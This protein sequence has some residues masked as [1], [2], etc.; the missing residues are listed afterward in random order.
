MS[1]VSK[2]SLRVLS[3]ISLT[4]LLAACGGLSAESAKERLLTADDFDF[5]VQ[6]DSSPSD[7]SI[8]N[9]FQGECSEIDTAER[10][11]L[12]STVV[13]KSE[14]EE[15]S[16]S[17]NGFSL[18]QYVIQFPTK[19]DASTFVAN[20]EKVARNSDCEWYYSTTSRGAY[21]SSYGIGSED[22]GNVRDLQTAFKVD[23][24]ESVVL[25][26]DSSMV[27]SGTFLSS[28]SSD[29][30]GAAF[31]TSGDLVVIVTYEVE[32]DDIRSSSQPVTRLNLE[33]VVGLA[34]KKLLG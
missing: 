1:F 21:G 27:I 11:Y 30:G 20:V 24:D 16:D 10:D 33:N 34:F 4:F 19:E 8:T 9:I 31:A 28:N 5:E 29:E 23:A 7:P 2:S 3:L 13:A 15:R 12:K 26:I 6:V 17:Q 25:D 18:E 22:F 32:S 14:Y